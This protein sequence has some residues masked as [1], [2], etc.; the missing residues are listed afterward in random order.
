MAAPKPRR[1]AIAALQLALENEGIPRWEQD[2]AQAADVL[3][4]GDFRALLIAP[5]VS[6]EAKLNGISTLLGD[7]SPLIINMVSLMAVRGDIGSFSRGLL[8]LPGTRQRAS[9]HRT[10]GGYVGRTAGRRAQGTDSQQPRRH[11]RQRDHNDRKHRHRDYRRGRCQGG[12]PV[13]RRQHA[14]QV[15]FHARPDCRP[16]RGGGIGAIAHALFI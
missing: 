3:S 1:Y 16:P 14:H 15:A 4:D 11:H 6:D 10:G 13:D 5:Q 9:R 8:D 12:R 2:M 7:V